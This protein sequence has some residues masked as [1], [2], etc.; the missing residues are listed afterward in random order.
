[1]LERMRAAGF[2]TVVCNEVKKG[3]AEYGRKRDRKERYEYGVDTP[4]SPLQLAQVMDARTDY[5]A[6]DPGPIL[7]VSV[8]SMGFRIVEVDVVNRRAVIRESVPEE[9]VR[10][11]VETEGA[12]PPFASPLLFFACSRHSRPPSPLPRS[13]VLRRPLRSAAAAPPSC[14]AGLSGR[15]CEVYVHDT[16]AALEGYKQRSSR[17]KEGSRL[18]SALRQLTDRDARKRY[19]GDPVSALLDDIRR[20]LGWA[21]SEEFER[22]FVPRDGRPRP[23][24]TNTALQLGVLPSRSVP[25]VVDALLPQP[26]PAPCRD[27]LRATLLEPPPAAVARASLAALSALRALEVPLPA[28]PLIS[29][30]HL[31]RERKAPA[32]LYVDLVRLLRGAPEKPPSLPPSSPSGAALRDACGD[33]S[34]PGLRRLGACFRASRRNQR[35]QLL[36]PFLRLQRAFVSTRARRDQRN[37][38]ERCAEAHRRQRPLR[39][40]APLPPRTPLA[41]SPLIHCCSRSPGAAS[42]NLTLSRSLPLPVDAQAFHTLR[43]VGSDPDL[44][45]Q[46]V[47]VLRIVEAAMPEKAL[48]SS[49]EFGASSE[50]SPLPHIVLCFPHPNAFHLA[51][52]PLVRTS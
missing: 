28:L 15:V 33:V 31:V 47:D 43:K 20:N 9:A 39:R 36:L 40:C 30:V 38:R 49:D 48:G 16:V 34:R 25:S 44:H 41:L 2:S 4:K 14:N 1:M 23:L 5:S 22:D 27:F 7:G 46:S 19:G 21:A 10:S 50:E 11:R 8:D 51:T 26:C 12:L 17:L 35:L 6:D 42:R 13:R 52:A 37:V 32:A 3:P 45:G 29:A 24:Y 18:A